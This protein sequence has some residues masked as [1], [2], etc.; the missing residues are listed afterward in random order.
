MHSVSIAVAFGF[1]ASQAT[2]KIALGNNPNNNRT[3]TAL[4]NAS[5]ELMLT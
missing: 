3:S 1:F 4:V 2:A 5:M